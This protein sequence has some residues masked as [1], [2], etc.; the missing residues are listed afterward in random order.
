MMV[1]IQRKRSWLIFQSNSIMDLEDPPEGNLSKPSLI[2]YHLLNTL[3][4][5]AVCYGLYEHYIFT[6]PLSKMEKPRPR[7][8]KWLFPSSQWGF[9]C[10]II[11]LLLFPLHHPNSLP[12]RCLKGLCTSLWKVKVTQSCL[13]LCKPMD[14][15]EFSSPEYQSSS[16]SLLQ[17]IF[18][19]Q[20]LNPGL[21]HCRQILYQLS[22][23]GL[24]SQV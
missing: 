23:K 4:D 19:I 8:D 14:C 13:S 16:L 2:I 7:K 20:G 12:L 21:L 5:L 9:I 18:P 15:I 1:A 22:H 17:G 11:K 10:V 24:Q 6:G 3:Y